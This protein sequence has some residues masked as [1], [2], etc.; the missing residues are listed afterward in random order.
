MVVFIDDISIEKE[1]IEHLG[2]VLL[3]LRNHWLYAKFKQYEFWF[4][5][6]SFLV[7]IISLNDVAMDP[8]TIQEDD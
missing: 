1:H 6:V 3:T 5:E 7:H 2:I 8:K 4:T